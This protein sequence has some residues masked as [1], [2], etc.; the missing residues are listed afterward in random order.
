MSFWELLVLAVGLAMDAFAVSI[1]KGLA[2]GKMRWDGALACGAWFGGFQALMP[3][4]GYLV[5]ARFYTYIERFDHWIAF[6]LLCL[7]GANMLREALSGEE[8]QLDAGYRPREMLILAVATSIDALAVDVT[9]A[10]LQVRIVTAALLIGLVT[11]A[12][13]FAGVRIGNL[14]GS[15]WRRPAV[16]TGG[17]MLILIGVRILAEH[18]TA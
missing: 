16:I 10:V 1:C 3:T 7:I 9:L 15:R 2:S 13:S 12:I 11:F 18:L 14:F 4:V 17:V 6:V 8:E 5:G